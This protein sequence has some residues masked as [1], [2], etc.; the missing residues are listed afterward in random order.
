ML[1]MKEYSEEGR[2]IRWNGQ[3]TPSQAERHAEI[4]EGS[5]GLG[6]LNL[7]ED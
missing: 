7:V 5:R 2:Q 6:S 3:A 1:S 4:R